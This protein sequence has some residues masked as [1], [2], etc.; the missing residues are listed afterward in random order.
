MNKGFRWWVGEV[1]ENF[2]LPI[3][4]IALLALTFWFSSLLPWWAPFAMLAG[5]VVIGG[6][7]LR[8]KRKV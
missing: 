1:L 8:P 7:W 5:V 6:L 2:G 3:L 4:G